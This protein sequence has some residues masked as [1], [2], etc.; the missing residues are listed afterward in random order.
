[1]VEAIAGEGEVRISAGL[2]F[3]RVIVEAEVLGRRVDRTGIGG[4][5][6]LLEIDEDE[7]AAAVVYL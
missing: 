6:L 5:L 4:A 2:S 7:D 1:M 3:V